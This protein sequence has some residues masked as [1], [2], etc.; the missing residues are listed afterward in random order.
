MMRRCR[1]LPALRSLTSTLATVGGLEICVCVPI[2]PV[3]NR[4][5]C[6]CPV[7]QEWGV[8]VIQLYYL[9]FEPLEELQITQRFSMERSYSYHERMSVCNKCSLMV[10]Q[11]ISI[12]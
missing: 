8:R 6:L 2:S 12:L 9:E 4:D 3:R 10:S 1:I 5:F 7:T 11:R